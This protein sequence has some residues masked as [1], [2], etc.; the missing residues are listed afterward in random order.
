MPAKLEILSGQRFGK[1]VVVKELPPRGE[2][3]LRRRMIQVRCECGQAVDVLLTNLTRGLTKSCGCARSE[4]VLSASGKSKRCSRCKKLLPLDRFDK[5]SDRPGQYKPRCRDCGNEAYRERWA[6][7]DGTRREKRLGTARAWKGKNPGKVRAQK[8]AWNAANAEASR[9]QAR[10][11]DARWRAKN[12]ELARKR[13]RAS[14]AK[15]PERKRA[16]D[17]EWRKENAAR[18]RAKYKAYVARRSNQMPSWADPATIQR[19]YDEAQRLTKETG[20]PHHVDH[21]VPLN[22]K[23]VCGLHC[24]ANLQVLPGVLNLSKGNRAWPDMWAEAA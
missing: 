17:A 16:Y 10:I 9:E 12:P 20:Q 13:V 7:M 6:A 18:C 24:E 8:L 3:K 21:V 11:R 1:L 23:L 22:S 14:Q 15:N 4:G 19:F 2:G 5:R